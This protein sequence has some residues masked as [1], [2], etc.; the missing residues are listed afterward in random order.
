MPPSIPPVTKLAL[1]AISFLSLLVFFN[2]ASIYYARLSA[3]TAPQIQPETDQRPVQKPA[4]P[5]FHDILAPHFILV[6][7]LSI[8]SPTTLLTSSFIETSIPAFCCSFI[9]FFYAARYCERIWSSKPFA[10]FLAIITIFPTI[11]AALTA[12]LQFLAA[13]Y[14]IPTHFVYSS[15]NDNSKPHLQPVQT[16]FYLLQPINGGTAFLLA[17]FV[18]LKQ[19]IPEH[20][21]ILFRG[22]IS[23]KV[24]HLVMPALIFYTVIG[25]F[26]ND[27]PYIVQTWSGF[28]VAWIYL[29]FYRRN[30]LLPVPISTQPS[31]P[32]PTTSSGPTSLRGD[33]SEVFAF[34]NF[35]YPAPIHNLVQAIATPIYSALVSIRLCTPFAPEEIE[36]SNSRAAIPVQKINTDDAERRRALALK[37]LDKKIAGNQ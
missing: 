17:F 21:I 27:I 36:L 10:I 14:S 22:A 30:D 33:A 18:A 28:L 20:S 15:D 19:L 23:L 35:F 37:A 12:I 34:A 25:A 7:S 8:T 24:K 4:L 6:P 26:L 32:I 31:G 29:R 2:R 13:S 11:L 1:I 9:T 5:V 3:A 16:E